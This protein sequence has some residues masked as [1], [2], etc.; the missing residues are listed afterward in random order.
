MREKARLSEPEPW[1]QG[2]L[3]EVSA[4]ARAALHALQLAK[5]DIAKWTDGLTD[6]ELNERPLGIAPIAFHMRHIARSLD[7]LLS[8]AE[9]QQLRPEQLALLKSEL[10]PRAS[11]AELAQEL[12]AAFE[13][14]AERIRSLASADL[15]VMR[16]VGS[17]KLPATLGGLLVHV[18]DHTQR[19]VGQIITTAQVVQGQG[20]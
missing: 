15:S 9:G 20:K 12:A 14:S 7:R 2:T 4:V 10:E 11:R 13:L 19:H 5:R 16:E 18:A 3:T 17:R 6:A 1:L 8:Y